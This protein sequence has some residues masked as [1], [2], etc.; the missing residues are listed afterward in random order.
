MKLAICNETF[1]HQDFPG[2][3]AEAARHGYNGLEIAPFTLGNPATLTLADAEKLGSIVRDHGLETVGFPL[4]SR[5]NR[6][7]PPHRSRP[8]RPR[9]HLYTACQKSF[10]K[11]SLQHL[12]SVNSVPSVVKISVLENER[13][14]GKW[15]NYARHLA[16][17]CSAM[18]GR[19]MVW[20]CPQQRN[21]QHSWLRTDAEASFI[22][23]FQRLSPHLAAAD[24]TIAFE[25]LGPAETNFINT[26]IS[27]DTLA[28]ESM[29]HLRAAFR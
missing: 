3:C 27:P 29:K 24:V 14:F 2:T 4:A 10:R 26:T 7:L 18:G 1:R 11:N 16:E 12:N 17:L 28:A 13:T 15:S 5:Q 20:G 19:I 23:F 6:R 21:L 25:F 9:P 8:R 22:D